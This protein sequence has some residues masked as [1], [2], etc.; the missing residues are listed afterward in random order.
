[1]SAPPQA[2]LRA[3][4]IPV[5]GFALAACNSTTNST[6][7]LSVRLTDTPVDGASQVVVTVTGVAVHGSDGQTEDFSF[8]QARSIDLPTLREAPASRCWIRCRWRPDITSGSAWTWI[9][10]PARTT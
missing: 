6:G 8:A 4:A 9:P 2:L 1:M 3:A 10:P 7:Q 5:M